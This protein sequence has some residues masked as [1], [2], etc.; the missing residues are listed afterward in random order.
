MQ[1]KKKKKSYFYVYVF[2]VPIR[3]MMFHSF[4]SESKKNPQQHLFKMLDV[5][6]AFLGGSIFC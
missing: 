5:C 6:R 2:Y 1:K 4:W 3:E